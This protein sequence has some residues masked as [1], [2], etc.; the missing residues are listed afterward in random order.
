[1]EE[2]MNA[3]E[4]FQQ[5]LRAQL[6]ES[7]TH[8]QK[9]RSLSE[10]SSP[11]AQAAMQVHIDELDAKIDAAAGK[12]LELANISEDAWETVRGNFESAWD[13]LST[14]V[15]DTAAKFKG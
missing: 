11:E 4:R 13:A 14:A 15:R 6:L 5:K 10:K 7:Q 2:P 8:V 3:K 12:L 1:M 9:L